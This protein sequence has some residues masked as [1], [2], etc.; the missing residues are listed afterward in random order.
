MALAANGITEG[1]DD[2]MHVRRIPT[3]LGREAAF[4]ALYAETYATAVRFR[5][6]ITLAMHIVAS[7]ATSLVRHGLGVPTLLYLHA[8]EVAASP[9]LARFAVRRSDRIV[10]VSRYTRGLGEAAGANP[11]RI[12]I[13]P[14]GVDP[15]GPRSEGPRDSV[16]TILTT[17]RLEDRYK[18]HDVIVRALPLIRATVPEV[19]WIVIGD[20]PLRDEIAASAE[21]Y[22]VREAISFEGV[23]SDAQR[24]AWLARAHVFAMP[25]RI[26]TDG[27]AGEGFGIVYL[28]AG[29]QGLPVVAGD[30]GGAVD[31]VQDSVTGLLVDAADPVA[32]ADAVSGLLS[33]PGRAATMGEAGR[34]RAAELSWDAT[35]DHVERLLHELI[36]TRR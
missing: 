35:A 22:G 1:E 33:D 31:A 21:A 23:V 24:D 29:A 18:G 27:G 34:R 15:I 19:R 10:A 28:E 3:R 11:A 13:V 12:E 9:A 30:R 6:D 7:P 8:K 14:P 25:S 4:A 5:P 2:G 20:G 36:A 17:A 16:P 32:V 26:P